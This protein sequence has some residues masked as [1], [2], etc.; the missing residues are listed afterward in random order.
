MIFKSRFAEWFLRIFLPVTTFLSS[1]FVASE[2]LLGDEIPPVETV[3][4]WNVEWF[5][6]DF[7]GNDRTDVAKQQSS[8]SREEWEWKKKAVADVIAKLNPAILCLQEVENCDVVYQLRK[9]LE[10]VIVRRD[11]VVRGEVDQNHWDGYYEIP[12]EERDISDH[13]PLVAEFVFK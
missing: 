6:D 10:E 5:Y 2:L 11:L 9:K 13:Y 4:T 12:Q 1:G 7:K 3:A 8:P